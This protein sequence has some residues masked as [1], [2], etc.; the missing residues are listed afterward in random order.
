MLPLVLCASGCTLS[1]K[2]GV[3]STGAPI[4]EKL[5]IVYELPGA[6][7]VSKS[8]STQRDRQ[9]PTADI[10]PVDWQELSWPVVRLEIAY[11]HPEAPA[12]FGRATV[13]FS[14]TPPSADSGEEMPAG[15]L[16]SGLERLTAWRS[17]P[18]AESTVTPAHVAGPGDVVRYLDLP[19]LELDL[20][21]VDLAN[22]GF[23]DDQQ[24][25]AATA[26]LDVTINR[27]RVAKRWTR[28]ARLDD[29]LSLVNRYGESGH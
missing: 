5:H 10:E 20:L 11:P 9:S 24:R 21:L 15:P 2:I 27:G 26:Q 6:D 17:K 23:F 19:K 13:V 1:E 18:A 3:D 8:R 22:S 14:D 29:L 7:A 28:E 4:Y 16:Q 12:Q 25:P